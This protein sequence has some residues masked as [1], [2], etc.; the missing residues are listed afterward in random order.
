MNT[1]Q[2][3]E[4]SPFVDLTDEMYFGFIVWTHEI[5]TFTSYNCDMIKSPIQQDAPAVTLFLNELFIAL[6]L[7]KHKPDQV[8]T[9]NSLL[10][11]P[12]YIHGLKTTTNLKLGEHNSNPR[13]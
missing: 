13:L 5:L 9:T 10:G 1:L 6:L 8:Y 3:E 11:T 12:A 2:F 4:A 7:R